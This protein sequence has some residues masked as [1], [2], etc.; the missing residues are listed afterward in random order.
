MTL[1][2]VDWV[3]IVIAG[4]LALHIYLAYAIT[5][6]RKDVSRWLTILGMAG[7]SVVTMLLCTFPL[8]VYAMAYIDCCYVGTWFDIAQDMQFVSHYVGN[9][10]VLAVLIIILLLVAVLLA[11][12]DRRFAITAGTLLVVLGATGWIG[13]HQLSVKADTFTNVVPE[14]RGVPV[15]PGAEDIVFDRESFSWF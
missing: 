10:W 6:A 14:A 11:R 12:L 5:R 9:F 13:F 1:G 7:L 4:V 3:I 2:P 15:Y 8:Y